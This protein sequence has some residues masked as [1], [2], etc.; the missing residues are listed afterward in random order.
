MITGILNLFERFRRYETQWV[1]DLPNN[2]ERNT[3][4]VIGEGKTLF[5]QL[6]FA[7]EKSAAR[8]FTWISPQSQKGDGR[9]LNTKIKLFL[10]VLPYVSPTCR[11]TAIIG[12]GGEE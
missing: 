11:V 2:P 10:S 7:D 3:V 6:L 9:L 8:L 4:Y 1:E 5:M 12:S